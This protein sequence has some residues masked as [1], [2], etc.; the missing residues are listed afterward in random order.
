[1]S[2]LHDEA[3]R[4]IRRLTHQ[5]IPIPNQEALDELEIALCE[6]G[7]TATIVECGDRLMRGHPFDKDG[8]ARVY[9]PNTAHIAAVVAQIEAER[10]QRAAADRQEWKGYSE[11]P[12]R[13]ADNWGIA[14]LADNP[15]AIARL[16]RLRDRPEESLIVRA[17][18]EQ[19]REMRAREVSELAAKHLR[20]LEDFLGQAI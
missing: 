17:A 12:P 2:Q 7:N 1:M 15:D 3:K 13:L 5:F 4:Q 19:F 16:K 8:V 9:F 14:L 6:A 20:Q 10:A 11:A 18:K